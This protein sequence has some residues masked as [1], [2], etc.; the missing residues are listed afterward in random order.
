[1]PQLLMGGEC[2]QGGWTAPPEALH[3]LSL[4][5]LLRLGAIQ[6]QRHEKTGAINHAGIG[7]TDT[8]STQGQ[9]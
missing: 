3:G 6:D 2:H 1:M 5:V 8:A 7:M 4:F 9:L